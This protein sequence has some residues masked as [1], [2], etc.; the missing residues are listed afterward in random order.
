[1]GDL[2]RRHARPY[3][4]A[5]G[6]AFFF[7]TV[8]VAAAMLLIARLVGTRRA[9]LTALIEWPPRPLSPRRAGNP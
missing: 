4:I 8:F 5:T 1:M 9:D 2:A 3:L 6:A 7:V